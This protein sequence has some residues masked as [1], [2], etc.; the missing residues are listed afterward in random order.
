MPKVSLTRMLNMTDSDE[1]RHAS[2]SLQTSSFNLK[3]IR[4]Y[5]TN[6]YNKNIQP[7]GSKVE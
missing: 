2:L 3:S 5:T 7:F 6:K 1:V 4:M